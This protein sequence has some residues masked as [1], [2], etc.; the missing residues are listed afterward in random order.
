MT[1]TVTDNQTELT[2]GAR[3]E[4]FR[5]DVD[6]PASDSCTYESARAVEGSATLTDV[7]TVGGDSW[8][9]CAPGEFSVKV[10][11]VGE[12]VVNFERRVVGSAS[13]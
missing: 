6:D 9:A 13:S 12:W 7:F 8:R 11:A 2:Y 1:A 3:Q 5:V 10:G 4:S